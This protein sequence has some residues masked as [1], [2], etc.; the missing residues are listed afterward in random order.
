M[1]LAVIEGCQKEQPEAGSIHPH[2]H[3]QS[4]IIKSTKTQQE[5]TNNKQSID[6]AKWMNT[7]QKSMKMIINQFTFLN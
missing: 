7:I 5:Q 3:N 4:S 1:R 2:N 6:H